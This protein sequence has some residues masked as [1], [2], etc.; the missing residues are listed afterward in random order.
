[1]VMAGLH[2]AA[3]EPV[4][5]SLDDA[6]ALARQ[7][8][9]QARQ[10]AIDVELADIDV[11]RRKLA[12]FDLKLSLSGD[13]AYQYSSPLP[14]T[15]TSGA[16]TSTPCPSAAAACWQP[17][18]AGG[19]H[20]SLN[21]PVWSGFTMEASLAAARLRKE[22]AAAKRQSALRGLVLSVA[23]AYWEVRRKELVMASR[24]SLARRFREFE[25]LTQQKVSSG[26]APLVDYD[27]ARAQTLEVELELTQT[28]RE[29]ASA[30]AS[31]ASLLQ[32]D[33][34]L[35]LTD[36]LPDDPPELPPVN[37]ALRIALAERPELAGA[38]AESRAAAQDLRAAKGAYWP[39]VSVVA[40]ADY[41][42]GS[43]ASSGT[44]GSGAATLSEYTTTPGTGS[45]TTT[46]YYG[47]VQ[48][49]WNVFDMLT[50][51]NNV[52]Q[53]G[54]TRDRVLT[55]QERTRYDVTLEVR[56]AHAQLQATLRAR[57]TTRRLVELARTDA[58]LLWRAY[59]VGA[60]KMIDVIGAQKELVQREAQL[61]DNAV[62]VVEADLGLQTA[63]GRY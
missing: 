43:Q 24:Q 30:R 25:Q 63:M 21:V 47:G 3:A 35:E 46:A 17:V 49:R 26:L 40:T 52:R 8:N 10:G 45:T 7:R 11:L 9:A 19:L 53:A 34:Q 14:S 50:T 38:D 12:Y 36:D 60:T 20:G 62:D 55:Q 29:L 54:L 15:T 32:T 59:S 6:L 51:W 16:A 22:S 1:M 58:G 2:A 39:Q 57:G 4:R 18:S 28:A 42:A 5:L 13:A 61:I 27:R 31:L 44:P 48:V 56:N 33:A 23:T 37:E 41:V